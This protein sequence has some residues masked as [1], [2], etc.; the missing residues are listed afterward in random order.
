MTLPVTPSQTIGPFFH[1]G[2]T[3][4]LGP[5]VV[6]EGTAG[7]FWV[8]GRVFDGTGAPVPDA[9]VET[10]QADRDGR[11]AHPDG[12]RGAVAREGFRGFGRCPTGTDG[13]FG[14]FTIKSGSVPDRR[15]EP[16]APHIDIS[17]FA[18]GLLHR[19][20]TR[21]Y[22]ADESGANL[23]DSLFSSLPAAR[24][25]TLVATAADDGYRS[26][27]HLQGEHETI[28]LSI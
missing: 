27:I 12:P 3:W 28:F 7:A 16:Q 17:L 14:V 19:V 15:G 21:L 25:G 8:R 5:Y 1:I 9:L 23:A 24:R 26:D 6:P 13:S 22:F 20:V 2:L 10:W 18:R 11:F 4:V